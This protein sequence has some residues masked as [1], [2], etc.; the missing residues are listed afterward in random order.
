MQH[1]TP[2]IKCLG[3]RQSVLLGNAQVKLCWVQHWYFSYQKQ[4]HVPVMT[5]SMANVSIDNMP[6]QPRRKELHLF[7][8]ARRICRGAGKGRLRAYLDSFN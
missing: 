7:Q 2:V 1:A 3:N 5:C 8:G 6:R 4:V